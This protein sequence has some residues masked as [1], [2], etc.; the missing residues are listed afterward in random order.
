M[1][2]YIRIFVY[3]LFNRFKLRI[4]VVNLFNNGGLNQIKLEQADIG[5]VLDKK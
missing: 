3:H 4:E 2:N 5:Y 1:K